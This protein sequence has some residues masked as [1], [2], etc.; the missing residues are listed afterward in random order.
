MSDIS[1]I[2]EAYLGMVSEREQLSEGSMVKT[3]YGVVQRL[4]SL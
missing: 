2:M 1:K 4:R 3:P